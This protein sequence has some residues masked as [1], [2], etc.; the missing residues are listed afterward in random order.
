MI[1]YKLMCKKCDLSFDSWFGSSLEFERLKKKN[2]LNCHRCG[3]NQIEKTLMTP[4]LSKKL[5]HK[6]NYKK[7]SKI[8]EVEKEIKK[9]QKF[10]KDNF[11]Y[12]GKNFAYEARSIHY[13]NKKKEKGIFGTATNDEIKELE[14][15]GINTE[16]VP[17][18]E[19]KSN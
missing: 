14:E 16:I 1:K 3:S 8:I 19:D 7:N 11:K 9:Y 10:I 5:D 13:N 17:W 15:E 18:M 6:L 2:F 12:V 4:R